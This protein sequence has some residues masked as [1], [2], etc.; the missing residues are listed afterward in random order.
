MEPIELFAAGVLTIC[1]LHL[2]SAIGVRIES[3]WR[4]VAGAGKT[5][6]GRA[7]QRSDW[8]A[9]FHCADLVGPDSPANGTAQPQRQ[10]MNAMKKRSTQDRRARA[11]A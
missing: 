8:Y 7:E 6:P 5:V 9:F 2:A 3:W 4:K 10:E 1:I 11:I